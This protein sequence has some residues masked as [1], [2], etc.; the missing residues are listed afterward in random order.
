MSDYRAFLATKHPSAPAAGFAVPP[1]ALNPALFPFQRAVTSWALERGRA[2]IFARMGLGKTPM[3]LTW[4]AEVCRHTGRDL[5]ILAPLVVGAQTAREGE[6]FGVPV[7]VCRD[8]ADARP[9]INVT[10]YERL[11]RFDPRRFVGAVADESSIVKAYTGVTKRRLVEFFAHLDYALACTA[12]PA[13]N[14]HLELGNHAE[15]LRVMSSH[16]MIARWFIADQSQM[17][18]YRLKRHGAADFWR[19]VATWGISLRRPSDLGFPDDGYALP[20]LH[21]HVLTVDVDIT[22]ETEGKLFRLPDL[23]ATGLH[24]EGR[25]TVQARAR[26]V[27]ELVNAP[28]HGGREC[29]A[30]WCNTDY[31]ADALLARIPDAVEVRG[32]QPI[33]EKEAKLAAFTAGSARVLITKPR[34]AGFG[35]NWQHCAHTAFVGLSYSF[36]QLHQALG[37]LHRFGQRRP[38]HAYIVGAATEGAIWEAVRRKAADHERMQEAMVAAGDKLRRSADRDRRARYTPAT[39]LRLPDWLYDHLEVAS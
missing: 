17:G 26:A 28:G 23:N 35:L 13:P 14:D 9:G 30:V 4:A 11:D 34:I 7:T 3:Q 39:P 2:A 25:R 1:D 31:E 18:T 19:W 36:E 15:L 29:W 6:K 38:V 10:N 16:E 33:E 32:S 12:T 22:T 8:Q 5:L 21:T 37:R 24:R 20:P 27:A